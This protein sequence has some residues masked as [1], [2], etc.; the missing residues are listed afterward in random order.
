[1]FALGVAADAALF[2][3]DAALSEL[4]RLLLQHSLVAAAACSK[5]PRCLWVQ[6]ASAG[7]AADAA[8]FAAAALLVVVSADDAAFAA[9]SAGAALLAVWVQLLLQHCWLLQ[10]CW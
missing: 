6:L 8:L 7:A 4:L 1:M 9:A 5:Q 2:A 10:P 3:A